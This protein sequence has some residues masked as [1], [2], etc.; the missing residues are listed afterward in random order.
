MLLARILRRKEV[1]RALVFARTKHR[2]NRLVWQLSRE[3]FSADA[4]HSNK[5]QAQRQKVLA[6]LSRGRLIVLVATDIVAR[7]I[8]VDEISH[9]INYEMPGDPENY[10]HRVGRTARW[11]GWNRDIVV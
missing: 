9:V 6:A 1:R 10:V 7:G 8:D 11:S 2:A 4:I 5:T 3:G